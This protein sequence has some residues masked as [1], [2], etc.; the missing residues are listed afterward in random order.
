MKRMYILLSV[1]AM[2]VMASLTGCESESQI[3]EGPSYVMFSDTMNISPAK[4]IP[5]RDIITPSNRIR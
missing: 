5:S 4:V 1:F 3:Y 2:F